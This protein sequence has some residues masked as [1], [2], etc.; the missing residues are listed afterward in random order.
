LCHLFTESPTPIPQVGDDNLLAGWY[1][2]TIVEQTT[3]HTGNH[4][5]SSFQEE[6]MGKERR[7]EPA[8]YEI[9]VEGC[10]DEDWSDWFEGMTVTVQ[11]AGDGSHITW[12]TGTVEDQPALRGLLS[13]IWDMNLTLVSLD[14]LG[15]KRRR[16]GE[17]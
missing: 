16:G 11:P 8:I 10:L 13:R 15:P 17:R 5:A 2:G 12:L 9:Q 4:V 1:T 6:R 3:K 14:R 7:T